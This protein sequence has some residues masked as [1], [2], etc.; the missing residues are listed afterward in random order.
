MRLWKL[1]KVFRSKHAQ[2]VVLGSCYV[3]QNTTSTYS[4]FA[5]ESSMS[6]SLSPFLIVLRLWK[7]KQSSSISW[8]IALSGER[9]TLHP[10][11]RAGLAASGWSVHLGEGVDPG[12]E[13]LL[14]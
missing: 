10:F 11:H 4:L 3:S 5:L 8:F 12:E 14:E 1:R 13:G 7:T 6:T 2:N 9:V